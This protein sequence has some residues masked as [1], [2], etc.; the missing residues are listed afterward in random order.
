MKYLFITFALLLTLAVSAQTT[1]IDSVAIAN[2]EKQGNIMAQLLLD[3]NYTD[4]AKYTYP[5]IIKM[6]GSEANMIAIIKKGLDDIEAQGYTFICFSIEKPLKIVHLKNS[7]QCVVVENIEMKIPNGKLTTTSALIG[8]S[9][10][11]ENNWTFI[12]THGADLKSLQ[13]TIPGLSNNLELPEKKEPVIIK[14]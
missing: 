12:D 14:D 5:P 6:A 11:K 9:T 7:M 13:K 10:D 1:A 2:A 3:K 8:V 4:F